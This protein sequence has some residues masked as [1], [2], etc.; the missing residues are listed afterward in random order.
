MTQRFTRQSNS[1]PRLFALLALLL[2][3]TGAIAS[4]EPTDL[5]DYYVVELILFTNEQ[6]ELIDEEY[7]PRD[8]QLDMPDNTA[9]LAGLPL[10]HSYP[11]LAAAIEQAQQ[12]AGDAAEIPLIT[13]AAAPVEV[14]SEA[15]SEDTAQAP[16]TVWLPLMDDYREHQAS[17]ERIRRSGRHRLLLHHSWLQKLGDADHAPSIIIQ[18]GDERD[19]LYELGGSIKL[20]KS[21]FLHLHTDLWRLQFAD[22]VSV[23]DEQ[24]ASAG[25]WPVVPRIERPALPAADDNEP[26]AEDS[27]LASGTNTGEAETT[28]APALLPAPGFS[29]DSFALD[30]LELPASQPPLANVAVMR[31]QRRLRSREIHYIDHPLFGLVVEIRPFELPQP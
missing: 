23:N 30:W 27:Q 12:A 4:D 17:A 7:W 10:A 5:S 29:A 16:A 1:H 24:P 22:N 3:S 18:A 20:F 28:A 25:Q 9:W 6:P 2:A 31:Q 14:T 26:P 19:G 8:I 13:P 21:R 11:E 15:D